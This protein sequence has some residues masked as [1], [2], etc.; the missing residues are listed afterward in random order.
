MIRVDQGHNGREIEVPAGETI[1]ICLEENR[2]TGFRWTC[3]ADGAPACALVEDSYQPGT[4]APGAGGT[5]RWRFGATRAG[6]SSI[7]LRY[8]RP[9]EKEGVAPRAFRLH[10]RV[11]G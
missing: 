5:H 2:T 9:W 11:I 7:E 3:D 10:V 6:E 4:G 1:E 8:R